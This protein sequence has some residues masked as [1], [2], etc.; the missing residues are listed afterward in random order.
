MSFGLTLILGFSVSYENG[1][2]THRGLQLERSPQVRPVVPKL[3]ASRHPE[4]GKAQVAG[5]AQSSRVTESGMWPLK[6]H[7]P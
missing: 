6:L 5:P 4:G 7:C 1:V 3:R 2:S